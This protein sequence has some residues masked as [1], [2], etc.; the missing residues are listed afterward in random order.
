[1]SLRL[2]KENNSINLNNEMKKFFYTPIAIKRY[3]LFHR[4][5]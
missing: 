4:M 5:R 2:T 1:M 3:P